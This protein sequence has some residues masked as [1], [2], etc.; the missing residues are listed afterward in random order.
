MLAYATIT[1]LWHIPKAFLV[2]I[3]HHRRMAII[4][5]LISGL[6]LL[7][8]Y[9]FAKY[10]FILEPVLIEAGLSNEFLSKSNLLVEVTAI[11][12]LGE[13]AMAINVHLQARK[14]LKHA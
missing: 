1:G 7:I 13:M 10:R 3:N 12:V 9:S 2:A 5:L 8:A 4:S 6:S 14:V 11:L